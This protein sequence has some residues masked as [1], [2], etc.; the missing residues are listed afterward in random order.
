MR[1]VY[2]LLA[3]VALSACAGDPLDRVERL[4]EVDLPAEPAAQPAV[5]APEAAPAQGGFLSGLFAR[6]DAEGATVAAEVAAEQA[7]VPPVPPLEAEAA[8]AGEVPLTEAAAAPD[9]AIPPVQ[10]GQDGQAVTEA[11]AVLAAGDTAPPQADKAGA[12]PPRRGL[13]GLLARREPTPVEAPAAPAATEVAQLP[14]VEPAPEVQAPE[15]AEAAPVAVAEAQPPRG[16]FGFLRPATGDAPTAADRP[17][18]VQP[19]DLAE[20]RTAALVPGPEPAARGGLFGGGAARGPKPGDPDFAEVSFGTSLPYGQIAR[21]CGVPAARLGKEVARYPDS[22]R[23]RYRIHDSAPDG[24]GLRTM[25]VTGFEDGCARQFT[26]ALALFGQFEMHEQLRYG[27]PAKTLPYSETDDAYETLKS[28]ECR[29][30][31]NKPC[32]N[33]M[34]AFARDG[35]FVSVYERFTGSQSWKNLL[36]HDGR[37]VAFDVKGR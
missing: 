11:A 37:V 14:P 5:A 16:L 34:D 19:E 28:R 12:E 15:A 17:G 26:A 3:A 13:L 24:I 21:V 30:G 6:R 27:L 9:P 22:G 2:A 18:P 31:K 8:A 25:Y 23:A 7:A 33:R 32:G 1:P 29:V 10:E 4:S 35:A 20:V 36:L